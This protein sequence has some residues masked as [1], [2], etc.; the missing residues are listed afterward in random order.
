MTATA[1]ELFGDASDI[2]SESGGED[3]EKAGSQDEDGPQVC[4]QFNFDLDHGSQ[5]IKGFQ[6]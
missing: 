5:K 3:K 4:C 1:D 6:G 2:S